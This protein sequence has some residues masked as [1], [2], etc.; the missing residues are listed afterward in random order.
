LAGYGLLKQRQWGRVVAIVVGVLNL[1]AFPLG[2][3]LGVYA[4]VVLLHGDCNRI[5]D[6]SSRQ[7]AV[8]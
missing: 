8:A 1:F 7:H 2:T 6:R 4:L 5:F 3:T